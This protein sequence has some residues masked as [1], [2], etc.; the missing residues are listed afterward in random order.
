MINSILNSTINRASF[1]LSD[2]KDQ[3][4]ATAKKRAQ[5][6]SDFKVP[7]PQDLKSKLSSLN[8]NSIESAEQ[9]QNIY[10]KSKDT[11][12]KTINKLERTKKELVSTKDKL[13]GINEKFDKLNNFIGPEGILGKLIPVLRELPLLIDGV[14]ATQVTPVVSGTVINKASDIKDFVKN[15][16]DKFDNA[17]KT[18]TPTKKYFDREIETLLNP[19]NM[20][21]D[22]IQ[23]TIDQLQLILDQLNNIFGDFLLSS[24]LIQDTTTG[25]ENSNTPLAGTTLQTYLS[26]SDNLNDVV[27]KLILPTRKIYYE[28]R[29]EGPGSELREA[30]IIEEPI[31]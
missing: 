5:E 17:L 1:A 13:L 3:I 16:I 29:D 15:S 24:N 23:K 20:G 21:I 11:L 18:L 4:L 6:N 30:G 9:A 14:L 2:S 19:L 31:D 25:D 12:K 10:K 8:P 22:N 27:E 26:N 28:V 7:S